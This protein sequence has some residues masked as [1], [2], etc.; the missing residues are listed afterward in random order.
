MPIAL[1]APNTRNVE[2]SIVKWREQGREYGV[3][4]DGIASSL[5]LGE[6][7]CYVCFFGVV[8]HSI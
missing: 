8:L 2:S 4:M 5:F 6:V 7:G 3:D 1:I